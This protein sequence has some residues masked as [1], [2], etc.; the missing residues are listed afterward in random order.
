MSITTV[1]IVDALS[2][3]FVCLIMIPRRAAL[4]NAATI[5]VG[6]AMSRAP[7]QVTTRTVIARIIASSRPSSVWTVKN[8]TMKDTMQTT[9]T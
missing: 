6:Y 7:G 4:A 3:V 2:K 9:G 5:A 8:Q 1:S